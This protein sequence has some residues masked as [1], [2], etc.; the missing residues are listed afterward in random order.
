MADAC[1]K[2][3]VSR[4]AA[5]GNWSSL[6][7]PRDSDPPPLP[8]PAL[9]GVDACGEGESLQVFQVLRV[10]K[11][12][13]REPLPP[14]PPSRKPSPPGSHTL[15]ESP[16][17]HTRHRQGQRIPAFPRESKG[18]ERE[19]GNGQWSVSLEREK[20]RVQPLQ[21]HHPNRQR[22]R[23]VVDA[24]REKRGGRRISADVKNALQNE[25]SWHFD[26]LQLEKVSEHRPLTHLGMKVSSLFITSFSLSI[27]NPRD[28]A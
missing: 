11:D 8:L 7:Q 17:L 18:G 1:R 9:E 12:E 26:V 2:D 28:R 15:G 13:E 24:Y 21:L 5:L 16:S 6:L 20:S 27:S 19:A 22:K 23:S 3:A 14:R 4:G 10:G 25:H